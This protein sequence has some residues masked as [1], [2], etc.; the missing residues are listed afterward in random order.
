[1]YYRMCEDIVTFGTDA[2]GNAVNYKCVL[3]TLNNQKDA[4]EKLNEAVEAAKCYVNFA[5]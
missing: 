2:Q 3:E 4:L 1:M 5:A